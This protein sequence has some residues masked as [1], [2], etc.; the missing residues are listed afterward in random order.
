MYVVLEKFELIKAMNICAWISRF[1]HNL[2]HPDQ[3]VTSPLTTEE[4]KKQHLFWVKRAQQS[5]EFE[6]DRLRLNLQPNSEGILECRGRIQGLY[7]VYL[8]D[9]HLYTRKLLH[10]E[11]LRTLHR[12]VGMTMTSVRSNHWVPRLRKLAKHTIRACQ[13]CQRFQAV[14]AANPPPGS[15]PMDRTQ[16]THPFHRLCG[17]IQIQEMWESER[18]SVHCVVC[19]FSESCLVPGF[20]ALTRNTRVYS[21]SEEADCEKG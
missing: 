13:G 6:D 21:E 14:A 5:C 7:P 4:L 20:G 11:H 16:G 1:V 12:G 8:P 9:K 18:Q 10:R 2:H 15:L 3:K 19:M 17:A